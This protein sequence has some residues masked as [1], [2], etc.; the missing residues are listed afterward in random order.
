[1]YPT[2]EQQGLSWEAGSPLPQHSANRKEGSQDRNLSS[3]PPLLDPP[4]S[5]QV[6]KAKKG[7][8]PWFK[9]LRYDVSNLSQSFCPLNNGA[10]QA[11]LPRFS[12]LLKAGN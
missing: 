6:Q 8:H 10:P 5:S 4:E 2:D 7:N 11:L 1:M 9:A 12:Q 3:F